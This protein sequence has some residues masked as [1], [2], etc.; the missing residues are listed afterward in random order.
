[1]RGELFEP[2]GCSAW[3]TSAWAIATMRAA[4]EL[5]LGAVAGAA[6]LAAPAAVGAGGG[7]AGGGTEARRRGPGEAA[8]RRAGAP[9]RAARGG[10]GRGRG[11]GSIR[12]KS[13]LD[14]AAVGVV[15]AGAGAVGAGAA[16]GP[17]RSEFSWVM[18]ERAVSRLICSLH[19]KRARDAQP[20][21]LEGSTTAG[22]PK[23][24]RRPRSVPPSRDRRSVLAAEERQHGLRGLVGLRE[25]ARAGLLKDLVLRELDHLAGH[26]HVADTALGRGQVLLVRREVVQRVLEAVLDRAE[27][28][29]E[30][31]D[32]ADRGVDRRDRVRAGDVDVPD[33]RREVGRRDRDDIAVVGADLER[34]RGGRAVEQ[35]DAVEVGA[36]ADPLDLA[37]EL[38][39]LGGDRRLVGRGERAGLE[40]D[41]ELTH[42]LEHR[43][44][45]VQRAL[46]RLHEA[47]TVLG[48][49][50]GLREAA[51]L[52]T[53][54][55]ADGESSCVVGR[56]V[57]A[58][59][60]A[61]ALHG[62]ARTIARLSKLAVGV[63]GL[64]VRV[65]AKGHSPSP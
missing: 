45:L 14:G 23:A 49:A 31:R 59:T 54:L 46:G 36:G 7:P 41:G 53:K 24:A 5:P 6:A 60:G 2:G 65:D 40:L 25:H 4:A 57:D 13:S 38:S 10:A 30:R 9:V 12:A 62:L 15:V 18:R 1:M 64:D 37:G 48:V 8:P 32:V 21:R 16:V 17:T 63:E 56:T 29:A 33:L 26:V 22:G 39:G 20:L 27:R 34:D 44:H 47:D 55:L 52:T 19:R 3:P 11:A 35:L 58:V 43:V 28:A 50:L 42:A 61:Q 51:N